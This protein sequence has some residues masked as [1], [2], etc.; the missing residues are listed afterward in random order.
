[1]PRKQPI[2]RELIRRALMGEGLVSQRA[3]EAS[4]T[5]GIPFFDALVV[6][7]AERAVCSKVYSEDLNH[8]QS[9]FGVELVNPFP[10][11]RRK[12]YVCRYSFR[13]MVPRHSAAPHLHLTISISLGKL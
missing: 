11:R 6:A 13:L 2:A 12:R 4:G 8:W 5:Y 9:Y 3:V 7:S 1:Q 10:C